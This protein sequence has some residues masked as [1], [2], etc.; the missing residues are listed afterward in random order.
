MATKETYTEAEKVNNINAMYILFYL[1]RAID[2]VTSH[3][4]FHQLKVSN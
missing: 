3:M 2:I 1:M 4:N